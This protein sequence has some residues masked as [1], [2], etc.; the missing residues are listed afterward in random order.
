[1]FTPIITLERL[2]FCPV[3]VLRSVASMVREQAT[4]K[5]LRLEIDTAR[6]PA[7]AYGDA[8]RLRQVLLNF[9]GNAIKFT[10]LGAITLAG[11]LLASEEQEMICRFSV[12]D[13]GIGIRPEDSVR[14][15]NSFEQLDGSTTRRYGGTGLGLAIARHLAQLMGGEVGVESTPGVGSRFWITARLGVARS[16]ASDAVLPASLIRAPGKLQGRVLLAEDEPVN[17]EIGRD[18]LAAIGLQVETA[19][20][21]RLA[22]ALFQQKSFDLLLLDIQMPELDGLQATQRIRALPGGGSIPIV[23]LTANVLSAQKEQCLAVGMNDFV[24]K[25]V[26][27]EALY[28]VLGK[29]LRAA[30]EGSDP[31]ASEPTTNAAPEL[32]QLGQ[33]FKQE[34]RQELRQKLT[35]LADLLNTGSVE[36]SQIFVRLQPELNA[37][38]PAECVQLQRHIAAFNYESALPWVAVIQK[39]MF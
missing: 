6:L 14:L 2:A 33:E 25:P 8:T 26:I 30:E 36:A 4:D 5:G 34:R 10:E 21:G 13:T 16:D 38:Y 15:F 27:P 28:A 3:D 22:V 35:M 37:A 31:V 20:N 12:T 32:P 11:E 19:E 7:R 39:R 24:A 17:C 1:M 23:A 9:A 29:Y 18:L